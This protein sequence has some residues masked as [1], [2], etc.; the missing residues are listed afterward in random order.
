MGPPLAPSPWDQSLL[1]IRNTLSLA[2]ARRQPSTSRLRAR[3]THSPRKTTPCKMEA[4]ASLVC[5][6]WTCQHQQDLST[7]LVM[8]SCV[9]STSSSTWAT[10][11]SASPHSK[12]LHPPQR[13][14][15]KC[16][17]HSKSALNA[18]ESCHGAPALVHSDSS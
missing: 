12:R 1:S 6:A 15:C 4:N 9:N 14:S 16:L 3:P 18:R 10:S 8:S 17:H 2:T 7:S 13:L 5:K 11:G